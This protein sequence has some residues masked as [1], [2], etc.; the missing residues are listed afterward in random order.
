MDEDRD[1]ALEVEPLAIG[2][3]EEFRGDGLLMNIDCKA[4]M[5]PPPRWRI[6]VID[7]F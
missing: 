1:F 3:N 7:F 2:S 5:L 6:W 4:Y